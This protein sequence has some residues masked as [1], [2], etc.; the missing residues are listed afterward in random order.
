MAMNRSFK[1]N[2]GYSIPAVGLG[3][4]QS[5]PNEVKE[6]VAAA[7]EIGYRHI[8]AAAVYGNEFE[9]GEGIKA[10]GVDRKDIFVRLPHKILENKTDISRD[11][12]K[13]LEHGS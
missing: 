5:G 8:D 1:L 2:S 6:A 13:T 4:W 11:H 9:V 7:L 3:T 12:G 10:S